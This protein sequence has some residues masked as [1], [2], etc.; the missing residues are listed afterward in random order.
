[1]RPIEINLA[2]EPFRNDLPIL[3]LLL[4]LGA[5]ALGVTGWETWVFATAGARRAE[6]R[7]QLA[8]HTKTVE[9]MTAEARAIT[10]EL[11]TVN[12][13]ELSSRAEFVAGILAERNFSWTAL[14]N[15]LERV[16]PW[17][18][19]LTSIRP[20]LGEERE[21]SVELGG[22][23]QDL[24]AFLAFQRALLADSSFGNVQ[25]H[26]YDVEENGTELAFRLSASYRPPAPAEGTPVDAPKPA[27][28][29]A[30]APAE[31]TR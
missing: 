1:M 5:A 29:P 25:P 16:T 21:M 9:A 18:V 20:L 30:P 28:A 15:E 23:A 6:I 31:G 14:F 8:E 26:G 19:R 10:A 24:E 4:A 12:R 13:A 22:I 17:N 11:A 3:V 27:E 7:G 2:A